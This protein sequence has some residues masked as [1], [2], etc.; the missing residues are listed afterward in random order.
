VLSV[1]GLGVALYLLKMYLQ[2][3]NTYHTRVQDR[4]TRIGNQPQ[5]LRQGERQNP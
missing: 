2:R 4:I 3:Q 5:P 1:W